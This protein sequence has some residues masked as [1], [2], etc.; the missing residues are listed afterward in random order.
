MITGRSSKVIT[1][2]IAIQNVTIKSP[3]WDETLLIAA[4]FIAKVKEN[5][6]I[7]SGTSRVQTCTLKIRSLS[8]PSAGV[9]CELFQ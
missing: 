1:V 9:R 7:E 3:C 2:L 4:V 8:I 6:T 5:M